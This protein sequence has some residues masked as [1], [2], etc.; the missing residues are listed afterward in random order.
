[1]ISCLNG[2]H[3]DPNKEL[4]KLYKEIQNDFFYTKM[5]EK[6]VTSLADKDKDLDT[7]ILKDS[8]KGKDTLESVFEDMSNKKGMELTEKHRKIYFAFLNSIGDSL[9]LAADPTYLVQ[10]MDLYLYST[11]VFFCA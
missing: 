5:A 4:H 3:L 10:F 7:Q 6:L 11:N 8:S 2:R 1:M 9:A